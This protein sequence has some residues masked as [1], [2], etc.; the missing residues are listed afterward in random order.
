MSGSEK[1]T[2]YYAYLRTPLGE[3][4][5]LTGA[6]VDENLIEL[7]SKWGEIVRLVYS[8]EKDTWRGTVQWADATTD[9]VGKVRKT[10]TGEDYL[11][12][13]NPAPDMKGDYRPTVAVFRAGYRRGGSA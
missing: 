3:E 5:R 6:R 7:K 2:K 13:W 1:G 11:Y 4:I 9:V 12:A 10:A 8:P